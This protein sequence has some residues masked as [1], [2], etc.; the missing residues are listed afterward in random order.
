MNDDQVL[1]NDARR[2]PIVVERR[3]SGGVAIIAQHVTLALSADE[4]ARLATFISGRP[5]IQ[6]FAVSTPAKARFSDE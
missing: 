6:R 1:I 3:E 2:Q 5:H 4:S